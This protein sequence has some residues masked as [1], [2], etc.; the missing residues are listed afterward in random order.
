MKRLSTFL[1]IGGLICALIFSGGNSAIAQT[2]DKPSDDTIR[3]FH[4]AI[5][6]GDGRLAEK[7]L[8]AY[9]D[10]VSLEL[11]DP[12]PAKQ[13]APLLTAI[14]HGQTH[15]T[16]MLISHG[17]SHDVG[18]PGATPMFR[19]AILGHTD[20]VKILV[21]DGADINGLDDPSKAADLDN[22]AHC[23]PLRDAVSC[24]H[25]E[26]ARYL[27]QRGAH[28]D[29]ASAAGLGWTGWVAKRISDHPEQTDF[30]DDW[31]YTPLCY[32]VA[33]GSAGTA[34]IVLSHGADI[35]HTFDD[36][37]TLLE[38]ATPYGY[39]DLIAVLLAHGADVN[40]KNKAG[41]TAL[42]FAIKYKQEDA[43]QLLR[44]HGGKRGAE[45]NNP[46]P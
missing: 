21:D 16:I 44:D 45:L 10:L 8:K 27:V 6:V 40:A 28:V 2:P 20:I 26:T 34:E 18:K 33:G 7:M 37:G 1:F 11:P 23:T 43:A 32:A 39:H 4:G 9:P 31:R 13:I 30:I 36:G 46:G 15:M 14:E 22:P 3:E 41:Q 29:L 42:D 12:D 24:G 38:L 5:A 19:A 35:T 25:M 17:A